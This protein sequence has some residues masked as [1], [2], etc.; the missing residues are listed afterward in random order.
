[1]ATNNPGY[2]ILSKEPGSGV[3]LFIE[4]KGRI[5][6]APIF[7][8]T[9]NEILTALNKPEQYLLAL[10]AVADDD[11]T[12]VRYLR[13]PFRGEEAAFFDVTSVNYEWKKLFERAEAPA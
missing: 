2:D 12:D 6:G 7:T 4:V 11:G 5:E 13:Q 1:M 10:V 3:Y 8:V 9:K